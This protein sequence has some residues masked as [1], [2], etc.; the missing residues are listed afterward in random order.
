MKTPAFWPEKGHLNLNQYYYIKALVEKCNIE[1]ALETGFCT[2]RSALAILNNCKNLK[3][4]ISVDIVFIKE[5]K[6]L[7]EEKFKNFTGIESDSKLAL[8]EEFFE[9]NYPEGIDYCLVDGDHSYGGCLNDL[10]SILPHMKVGSLLVIDD[11]ES[12]PPDGCP[13]PEVTSACDNFYRE[14]TDKL[15]REKWHKSGKGFCVFTVKQ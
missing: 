4:M 13:I 14:N 3:R 11:Y 15:S 5:R 10:R 8:T 2:G 9:T 12:G 1:Y 6:N 7:L